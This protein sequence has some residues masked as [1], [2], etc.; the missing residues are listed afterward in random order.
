MTELKTMKISIDDLH[1]VVKMFSNCS[2]DILEVIKDLSGFPNDQHVKYAIKHKDRSFILRFEQTVLMSIEEASAITD[3]FQ[4][5]V[6]KIEMYLNNH[7][8]GCIHLS[9]HDVIEG[10]STEDENFVIGFITS[11]ITKVGFNQ[12][13]EPNIGTPGFGFNGISEYNMFVK[14][15]LGRVGHDTQIGWDGKVYNFTIFSVEPFE[16]KVQQNYYCCEPGY[17]DEQFF[18]GSIR[19]T[20]HA[21]FFELF[22]KKKLGGNTVVDIND[23]D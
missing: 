19:S 1:E 20:V 13:Y 7:P 5:P 12:W 8:L 4:T 10:L 2:N 14:S 21:V 23:V 17:L 18:L 15:M 6:R 16:V 9:A 3:A 22:R 11:Q